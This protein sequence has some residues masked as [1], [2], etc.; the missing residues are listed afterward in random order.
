MLGI[1]LK[2]IFVPILIFTGI[3]SSPLNIVDFCQPR[4]A[5]MSD[6]WIVSIEKLIFYIDM[7]CKYF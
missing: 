1:L 7:H 4:E 5:K 3:E 6:T 2:I